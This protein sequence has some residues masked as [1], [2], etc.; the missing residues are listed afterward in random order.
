[1]GV[2]S[3]FRPDLADFRGMVGRKSDGVCI[4]EIIQEVFLEVDEH[5]V[6]S[7]DFIRK[8]LTVVDS[9]FMVFCRSGS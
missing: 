8:E 1:M 4:D 2:V 9:L 6:E 3:A 7:D 5:G